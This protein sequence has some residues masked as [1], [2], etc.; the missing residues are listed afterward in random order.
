MKD[1][2]WHLRGTLLELCN[3]APGCDCNFRGVPNSLEGN[4]E[5]LVCHLVEDGRF[6]DVDLTGTTFVMAYWW[7]GAI[8]DK[9]GRAHGFIDCA[10]DAQFEVL[11]R[12]IRGQEGHDFFEIF[13]S[14]YDAPPS[15]TRTRVDVTLAGKE[16]RFSVQGSAAAGTI[17]ALRNPVTG[18]ENDVRIVKPGGFIW[19]DGHV[20]QGAALNVDLP[21]ISFDH[22]GRHAVVASFDWAV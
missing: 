4:C 12:I 5:A 21:G 1:S 7:P 8:H 15:L 20:A 14:T 6:G 16:S 13:N 2:S 18:K 10:E 11:G 22:T 17:T 9:G 19:K 3:C